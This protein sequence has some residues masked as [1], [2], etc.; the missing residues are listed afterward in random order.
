M[1]S[2]DQYDDATLA[3]LTPHERKTLQA[4]HHQLDEKY[5]EIATFIEKELRCSQEHAY[6]EAD[7]AIDRWEEDVEMSDSPIK[8]NSLLQH[9][10]SAHHEIAEQIMDIRDG[11]I[12]RDLHE[13]PTA[14][15]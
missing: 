12:E 2:F 5:D 13:D 9:L 8:P 14:E 6:A 11:A 7:E 15:D 3:G 4:L 1:G 10:L